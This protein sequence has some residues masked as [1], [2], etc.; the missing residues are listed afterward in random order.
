MQ[1]MERCAPVF[2]MFADKGFTRT[3]GSTRNRRTTKIECDEN[4]GSMVAL[5]ETGTVL[6]LRS[7]CSNK[8][9]GQHVRVCRHVCWRGTTAEASFLCEEKSR[10]H[11]FHMSPL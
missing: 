11:N 5:V 3:H 4:T 10:R 2:T 8:G 9:T 6:L 1:C 7:K